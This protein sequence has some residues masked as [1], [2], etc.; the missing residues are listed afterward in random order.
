MLREGERLDAVNENLRLIQKTDGL[1]Y[2]TDAFLLSAYPPPEPRG[3]AVELGAGTGIVSLLCAAR[4]QY[5]HIDA[6]EVQPEFAELAA[7]NA[8]LNGQAERVTVRCA[9]LR[10]LKS[11]DLGGEVDAVL[12]NPPYMRADTGKLNRSDAKAIARHELHGGID[13]FCAAAARLL[14]WGGRF[15]CVWRPD[16]LI[17]LIAAMRTHG[18]EPK[19][20]T[21]VHADASTPASMVLI[22]A[23]RGGAPS[24]ALTA[25]LLLYRD[26]PSVTP[27][28]MTEAA[29][30]IYETGQFTL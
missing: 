27:R 17:D 20:M 26:P 14:R 3:R 18:L 6:I 29:A 23:R 22:D 5:A 9:D 12:A 19:R 16:R 2:G 25:P 30:K 7:R 4:G 10:T 15:V 24:L 1:T 13:D 11:A 28:V 21:A 8:A